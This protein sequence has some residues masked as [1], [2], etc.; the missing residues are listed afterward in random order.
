MFLVTVVLLHW[1]SASAFDRRQARGALLARLRLFGLFL[2]LAGLVQLASGTRAIWGLY[3]PVE[4]DPGNNLIF[5]PFVNRNH[6]ATYMLVLVPLALGRLVDRLERLTASVGRGGNLRRVLITGLQ[7]SGVELLY[8]AIPVAA[9][10]GA[11]VAT[12]SRGALAA[13]ALAVTCASL[14]LL[15]RSRIPPWIVVVST[16]GLVVGWFGLDRLDYRFERSVTE[17]PGRTLVWRSAL[18]HMEG[19][20]LTGWGFNTF[21]LV[22]VR[23]TAW[24]LPVGATPWKS[25]YETTIAE[26]ERAGYRSIE[27]SRGLT[28]YREAHNDYLQLLVEVG[29]FGLLA[30]LWGIVRL[31]RRARPDPWLFAAL[32]APLVHALVEFG[33]QTPAVA[34]L[35]AVVAGSR[36]MLPRRSKRFAPDLTVGNSEQ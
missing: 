6:F 31:L 29:V 35:F 9:M 5:G 23:T 7:R 16:A 1:V 24:Q 22:A 15:G 2:S 11:L 27:D 14:M 34:F 18:G 26:V 20:W 21:G 32:L 33:L 13:F 8:A 12:T 3:R 4:T 30:A 17:A 19:R 28:W 36:P 25:P 10:L